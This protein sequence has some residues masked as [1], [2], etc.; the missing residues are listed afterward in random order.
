VIR[1]LKEVLERPS[2]ALSPRKIWPALKP[3][4][5]L[6]D[7]EIRGCETCTALLTKR[8]ARLAILATPA[9]CPILRIEMLDVERRR[10][11]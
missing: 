11:R 6:L 2:C 8:R 10:S 5:Q 3:F 1:L 4:E 7:G 9:S